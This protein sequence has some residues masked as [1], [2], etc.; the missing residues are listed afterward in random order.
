MIVTGER[1]P[2]ITR[3]RKRYVDKA[4]LGF[5]S[6]RAYKFLIPWLSSS[7]DHDVVEVGCAP[8]P[9]S[10]NENTL[11]R[12]H[13]VPW[14]CPSVAK[15]NN[16][17]ARRADTR[18][19]PEVLQKQSEPGWTFVRHKCCARSKSSQHLGNIITSAMLPPQFVLVLPALAQHHIVP[20]QIVAV[21]TTRILDRQ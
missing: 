4:W 14:C 9:E 5:E 19:V 8:H 3:P 16:I 11:W 15:R 18:N 7:Q 2:S 12:Q 17:A 13:C 20:E 21:N 6:T 1:S 10:K